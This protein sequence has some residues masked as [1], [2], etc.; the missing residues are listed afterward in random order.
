MANQEY[1]FY[2]THYKLNGTPIG[3][4]GG[5]VRYN[6]DIVSRSVKTLNEGEN[7]RRNHEAVETYYVYSI[8]TLNEMR[9]KMRAFPSNNGNGWYRRLTQ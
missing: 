3:E 4:G 9:Q 6:H 2:W 1:S 8:F 7:K 5:P